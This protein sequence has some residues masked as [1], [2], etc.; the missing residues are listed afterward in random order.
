M[1]ET[2][3]GRVWKS[4]AAVGMAAIG[5]MTLA[6]TDGNARAYAA[7]DVKAVSH[8]SACETAETAVR[9]LEITGQPASY[10][11]RI[12][13]HA[14]FTVKAKGGVWAVYQWQYC[15]PNEDWKNCA[16]FGARGATLT[17][18][19]KAEYDGYR[20]RCVVTDLW[21]GTQIISDEAEL[22]CYLDL[23]AKNFPDELFRE[24][25]RWHA[26]W[27]DNGRLE[28]REIL[29][30]TSFCMEN[31]FDA[32]EEVKIRSIKGIEYFT[33]VDQIWCG[34]NALT[35]ID[36]SKNT[37]LVYLSVCGNKLAKIDVSKNRKLQML[38]VRNNGMKKLDVSKNTE[39]TSLW[40]GENKFTSIDV[41]KNRKL[42]EFYCA[43]CALRSVDLSKNTN[44]REVEVAFN[45]L[46]TLDL[47]ANTKLEKVYCFGN[48]LTKIKF[49]PKAPIREIYCYDNELKS[50]DLSKLTLLENLSCYNNKLTKI[51]VRNNPNLI[52][53]DCSWNE[54]GTLDVSNNTQLTDLLCT[55][56][57]LSEL[58]LSNNGNLH[59]LFTYGNPLSEIDLSGCPEIW[60][61]EIDEETTVIGQ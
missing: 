32:P 33:N 51:D 17:V 23:N 16:G 49:S 35:Q 22:C 14:R 19:M 12:G 25:V 59:V 48:K 7:S 29:G 24:Q 47:R 46:T 26:D 3:R 27:N 21:G 13:G 18:D 31:S 1:K 10:E 45:K 40:C 60:Q 52:W 54:I 61:L 56:C 5:A 36:V 41:S 11:G 39:L 8:V 50:L 42:E 9:E 15:E 20:F 43:E 6:W 58:D 37:N 38:D 4:A 44:L 57:G 30:V 34:F 28:G 2:C 55:Y 53:L